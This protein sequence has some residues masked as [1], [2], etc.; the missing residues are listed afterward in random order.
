MVN[1]G[2]DADE[3]LDIE[4]VI[5]DDSSDEDQNADSNLLNIDEDD[6]IPEGADDM[7]EQY[8]DNAA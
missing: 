7:D 4:D 3:D 2:G 5:E 1:L 8:S 6:L